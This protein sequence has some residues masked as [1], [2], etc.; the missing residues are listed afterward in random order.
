MRTKKLLPFVVIALVSCSI[1]QAGPFGSWA[2]RGVVVNKTFR[3]T[4]LSRSLG[5]D[6]IYRLELRGEDKKVRRQMVTKEIFLAYA[7]GDE[8]DEHAAPGSVKKARVAAT[9][10]SETKPKT[11][12]VSRRPR[13]QPRDGAEKRVAAGRSRAQNRIQ[14]SL[15]EHQSSARNAARNGRFLVLRLGFGQR[16]PHIPAMPRQAFPRARVI[17]AR[18]LRQHPRRAIA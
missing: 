7:I 8:F 3:P 11:G 2:A 13:G 9:A 1:A 14:E 6:G 12:V 16:L 15:R 17:A 18:Q 10:K 4:P 5:V